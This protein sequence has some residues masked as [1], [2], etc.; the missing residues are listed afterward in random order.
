MNALNIKALENKSTYFP[1]I[2]R[3]RTLQKEGRYQCIPDRNWILASLLP[4]KK[5]SILD[6]GSCQIVFKE[7]LDKSQTAQY[8]YHTLDITPMDSKPGWINEHIH[9]AN[10]PNYPVPGNYFDLIICSDAIEHIKN[11]EILL[12]ECK[13]KLNENGVLFLTTPNYSSFPYIR[14]ILRGKMYHDPCGNDLERYCFYEHVRYFTTINL[15]PYL[16]QQGLFVSHLLLSGLSTEVPGR[17]PFFRLC[18][19][20][21]YNRFSSSFV[22]FCHQTILILQKNPVR[23]QKVRCPLIKVI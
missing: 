23:F 13:K 9:D 4:Q 1:F 6:I 15:I 8:E 5:L 21:F 12:K 19:N 14:N 17:S 16:Q 2:E 11:H 22:R 20:L 3:C 7:L 18:M 10:I